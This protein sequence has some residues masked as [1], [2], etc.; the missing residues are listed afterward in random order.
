MVPPI[1]CVDG[2]PDSANS[3]LCVDGTPISCVGG[4]YPCCL[5]GGWRDGGMVPSAVPQMVRET[6]Q[7]A[8]RILVELYGISSFDTLLAHLQ[9][10]PP[11]AHTPTHAPDHRHLFLRSSPRNLML[12]WLEAL[13]SPNWRIRHASITLLGDLLHR[14]AGLRGP[15]VSESEDAAAAGEEDEDEDDTMNESQADDRDAALLR[16]LGAERKTSVL[17]AMYLARCDLTLV[18]RQTASRVWK[19]VVANTPKALKEIL[20]PLI[21]ILIEYLASGNPDKREVARHSLADIASKL[22]DRVVMTML[23]LLQQ[24]LSDTNDH[25]REGAALGLSALLTHANKTLLSVHIHDVIPAVRQALC[26][27]LP[28]V[29]SAAATSFDTLLRAV[30]SQAIDEIVPQLLDALD[31]ENSELA[32]EGL[33]EV[34]NVKGHILSY[35]LPK[36]VKPPISLGSARALAGLAVAAGPS[37]TRHMHSLL[38]V[39][40]DAMAENPA[41]AQ[42][43]SQIVCAVTSSE[44][45]L[46]GD[47]IK[48]LTETRPHLRLNAALLL[49]SYFQAHPVEDVMNVPLVLL[50]LACLMADP[51]EAVMRAGWTAVG[52]VIEAI[53]KPMQ[54]ECVETL[55][56]ALMGPTTASGRTWAMSGTLCCPPSVWPMS[57][58]VLV[59]GVKVVLPVFIQALTAGTPEQRELAAEGLG[60]MVAMSSVE[61]LRSSVL[62][63]TG[64]LIRVIADKFGWRVKAA[65]LKTFALLITKIGPLIKSFVSPLQTTFV[66][67]LNDPT[68]STSPPPVDI[69]PNKEVRTRAAHALSLL[70]SLIPRL[71]SLVIELHSALKA[72]DGD[73]REGLL[74]ALSGIL[75]SVG[76]CLTAQ[77]RQSLLPTLV[78]LLEEPVDSTRDLA[79]DT[80]AVYGRILPEGELMDML[81]MHILLSPEQALWDSRHA[82][83]RMMAPFLASTGGPGAVRQDERLPSA[84]LAPSAASR[85][86]NCYLRGVCDTRSPAAPAAALEILEPITTWMFAMDADDKAPIR[87]ALCGCLQP[88]L[89]RHCGEAFLAQAGPTTPWATDTVD[90]AINVLAP[91]MVDQAAD[92]RMASFAA[93]RAWATACP[94]LAQ[95]YMDLLVPGLTQGLKD[96]NLP[97]KSAAERALRALFRLQV[98][99]TLLEAYE[100]SHG[101]P[102]SDYLGAYCRRVLARLEDESED[103]HPTATTTAAHDDA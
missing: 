25:S 57:V 82:R 61:G 20:P 94:A 27:K 86:I 45:V 51:D 30:G 83:L 87:Q 92:V 73:I 46:F 102:P 39:L 42:P 52:Q 96:R 103:G 23:P 37:L 100:H 16:V 29:R 15:R 62:A 84:P 55:R 64:P 6:A 28:T 77:T 26:D 89:L 81:Q 56:M 76:H 58:L 50:P 4:W 54:C 98:D 12:T 49:G 35:V 7:K 44:H 32:L 11:S 34:L 91:Y 78:P 18:V 5:D 75:A 88:L 99:N 101:L 60:D 59:L 66:K 74:Q 22:T 24:G 53:P 85:P 68:R 93:L 38:P 47:L 69:T 80:L 8:C 90:R 97:A 63:I 70:V 36:L 21:R 9:V 41:I 79:A 33:K 65:I 1:S 71:D 10:T 72:A 13:T 43:A 48:F 14:A 2:T 31:G 67:A 40:I 3:G 95:R 17:V 19:M